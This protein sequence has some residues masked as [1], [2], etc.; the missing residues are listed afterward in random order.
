MRQIYNEMDQSDHVNLLRCP[1]TN[2]DS[3]DL[4]SESGKLKEN[5]HEFFHEKSGTYTCIY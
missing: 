3:V 5:G 4:S 1:G 2:I